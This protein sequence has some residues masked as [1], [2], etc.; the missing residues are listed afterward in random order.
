MYI[1]LN[2]NA[3]S[4][5]IQQ[6]TCVNDDLDEDGVILQVQSFAL[7]LQHFLF[8]KQGTSAGDVHWHRRLLEAGTCWIWTERVRQ[9]STIV[10]LIN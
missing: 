10:L 1:V 4:L 8:N 7:V 2:L 9:V 6:I 5:W 3:P